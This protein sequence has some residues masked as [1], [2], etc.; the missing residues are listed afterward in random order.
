LIAALEE[1]AGKK[2]I[3]VQKPEQPGDVPQ[4]FAD[5]HKAKRLLGWEPRTPLAEGLAKYAE[6]ALRQ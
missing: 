4:T 3:I 6:W 5:V 2:A 1:L